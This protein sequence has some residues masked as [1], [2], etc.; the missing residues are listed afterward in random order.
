MPTRGVLPHQELRGIDVN[1][2]VQRIA[3]GDTKDDEL[4]FI[5]PNTG[6]GRR[7]NSTHPSISGKNRSPRVPTVSHSPHF[8][9]PFSFLVVGVVVCVHDLPSD[10]MTD[11]A[12]ARGRLGM[13]FCPLHDLL[14]PCTHLAR[15][16]TR[17]HLPGS[18][19]PDLGRRRPF[20]SVVFLCT[21]TLFFSFV[22]KLHP[23]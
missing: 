15:P 23:D 14:A 18:A 6:D 1:P 21:R 20:P 12:Q 19:P 16:N 11:R 10:T 9:F 3:L 8:F 2:S 7:P 13:F 5:F 22:R 4:F 17:T